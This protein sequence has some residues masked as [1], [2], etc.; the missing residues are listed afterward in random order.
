MLDRP[1]YATILHIASHWTLKYLNSQ[2]VLWNFRANADSFPSSHALTHLTRYK[3]CWGAGKFVLKSI[4]SL[5]KEKIVVIGDWVCVCA[6]YSSLSVKAYHLKFQHSA[7]LKKVHSIISLLLFPIQIK[8]IHAKLQPRTESKTER[9]S[10][11][12]K[13]GIP[14]N[15]PSSI[16]TLSSPD[17]LWTNLCTMPRCST[18]ILPY[19]SELP[20]TIFETSLG[21]VGA[22]PSPAGPSSTKSGRKISLPSSIPYIKVDNSPPNPSDINVPSEIMQEI[23]RVRNDKLLTVKNVSL[24]AQVVSSPLIVEWRSQSHKRTTDRKFEFRNNRIKK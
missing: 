20:S 3:H 2:R 19:T 6:V 24:W 17:V 16:P 5:D 9:C 4:Q 10:G 1:L 12:R 7:I 11:T 23:F 22:L 18:A 8:D 13:F 15:S 14:P 21:S